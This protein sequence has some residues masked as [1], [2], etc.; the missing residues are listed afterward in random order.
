MTTDSHLLEEL[1]L[2][3][4]EPDNMYSLW[5]DSNAF[6]KILSLVLDVD[7]HVHPRTMIH[8]YANYFVSF[9]SVFLIQ[10][11]SD[12]ERVT[13]AIGEKMPLFMNYYVNN[14]LIS[15]DRI[16]SLL[17]DEVLMR[18]IGEYERWIEYPLMLR[19]NK[20]ITSAKQDEIHAHELIPLSLKI[21]VSLQEYL[22]SWAYEEGKLSSEGEKFF[23]ENFKK[24]YELLAMLRNKSL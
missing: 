1:L 3:Y 2:Y 13:K 23:K 8:D 15:N 5:L 22:L 16:S 19:A 9:T 6:G 20:L 21:D 18:N 12:L 10:S 17:K 14:N 4:R 11:N 7:F 24:K